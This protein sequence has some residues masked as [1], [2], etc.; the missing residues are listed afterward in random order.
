MPH[1]PAD[2][3]RRSR[4]EGLVLR[5]ST[6]PAH[7]QGSIP[8]TPAAR[9]R[10]RRCLAWLTTAQG[11]RRGTTSVSQTFRRTF[12]FRFTAVTRL[13]CL[14]RSLR[15]K[16]IASLSGH[17]DCTMN[18]RPPSIAVGLPPIVRH[19]LRHAVKVNR[20]SACLISAP[21]SRRMVLSARTFQQLCP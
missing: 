14:S 18:L 12:A 9:T 2:G 3:T 4:D 13:A 16:T 20:T 8:R 17:P 7:R 11:R 1:S 21:D 10:R 5:M 19:D 6:H 15:H